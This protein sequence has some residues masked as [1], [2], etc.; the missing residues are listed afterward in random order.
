MDQPVTPFDLQ[1]MFL[2]DQPLLFYAEILVRTLLI[3]L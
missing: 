3:Y 2:G 1:R